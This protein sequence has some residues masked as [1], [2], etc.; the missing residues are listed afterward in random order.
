MKRKWFIFILSIF[1]AACSTQSDLEK[2]FQC[3][4]S[5][6]KPNKV[7][8]DF[9]KNFTLSI[10]NYWKTELYYNE[11]QSEIICADT[12][13]QLTDTFILDVSFNYGNLKF[14]TDFYRKNDSILKSFNYQKTNSNTFKFQSKSGYYNIIKGQKNKFPYNQ[15]N[16]YVILSENTYLYVNSEIYGEDNVNERVC[17][18]IAIINQIEFSE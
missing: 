10:P 2:I 7:I 13:K 1:L 11:F 3:N 16:I 14:D 6:E 17:E 12:T 18:S 8:S 15:L 5:I 9:K 4:S